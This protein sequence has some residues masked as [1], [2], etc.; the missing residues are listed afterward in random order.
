MSEL[1]TP[2]GETSTVMTRERQ[3]AVEHWLL[4][5]ADDTDLAR[6]QWADA[7]GVALLA[8]GG[9][10]GAVRVPARL[11][12]AAA[13]TTELEEVDAHLRRWFSGGGAFLDL[14]SCLYYFLVPGSTASRWT[15]S[16]FPD[17]ACLGRD[18]FLGVPAVHLTEPRGRSY[19]CQPMDGPADL[20]DVTEV[21][22]LLHAAC[23]A[24]PDSPSVR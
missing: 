16:E 14:H 17:V 23:A 12:W 1:D 7:G 10:L 3:L 21:W 13:G 8:C 11:V 5:A 24:L 2:V 15:G 4:G 19:W 20:C 6:A 18:H 22:Q 9:I